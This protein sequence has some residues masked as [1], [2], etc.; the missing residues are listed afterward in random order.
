MELISF[1][2]LP[3]T[4]EPFPHDIILQWKTNT[5]FFQAALKEKEKKTC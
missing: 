1:L 2:K 4:K 3:E 5:L